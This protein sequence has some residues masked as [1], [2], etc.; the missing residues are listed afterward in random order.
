MERARDILRANDG[1]RRT[2]EVYLEWM[3]QF[4]LFH[5]KQH[6]RDRREPAG[7]E[8]LSHLTAPQD[9]SS[10]TP[11]QAFSALLFLEAKAIEHP[12]RGAGGWSGRGAPKSCPW[13]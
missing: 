12:L 4:I 7:A 8:F 3:R 2:E 6:P 10:S 1:S 11:N 13:R 9:V 5:S